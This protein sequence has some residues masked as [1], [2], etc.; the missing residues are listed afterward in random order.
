MP[1]KFILFIFT[2]LFLSILLIPFK[3]SSAEENTIERWKSGLE[4]EYEVQRSGNQIT[5]TRV[6]IR[7]SAPK[8]IIGTTALTGTISGTTFTGTA[9]YFT[10]ECPPSLDRNIPANGTVSEDGNTITVNFDSM[11]YDPETCQDSGKT[12]PHSATFTRISSSSIT[13]TSNN[14]QVV[15]KPEV[16]NPQKLLPQALAGLVLLAVVGCVVFFLKKRG[17]KTK[18]S[19]KKR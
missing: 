15:S 4:A 7:S 12:N 2:L 18:F 3:V 16:F 6:K 17:K 19:K 8:R 13:P 10:D 5:F 1:K 11:L 14:V 9:H